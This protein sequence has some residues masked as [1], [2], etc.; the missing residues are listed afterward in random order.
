MRT[1]CPLRGSRH[2][3]VQLKC[4]GFS[5]SWTPLMRAQHAPC[6]D[7]RMGPCAWNAL[8]LQLLEPVAVRTACPLRRSRHR[9]LQLKC[10]CF[11]SSWNLLMRAQHVP[12]ADHRM[13]PC[14]WNALVLQLLEPVAVR[15][16][17]PLL[18]S[19]HGFVQL[20]CLGF[21]SSWGPLMPAQHVPCA[22]HCMG[23]CTWNA[24][25][26]Q[27]LEPAAV[28]RAYPLCGS[29]PRSVQLKCIGFSSSWSPSM[30]AQHVPGAD[31]RMGPC[32]WDA[33]V[34]QLLEPAA[35]RRA[36]PLRGSRH[37]SVQPKCMVLPAPGAR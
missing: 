10:L 4:L 11:S 18:G 16:A 24:L 8:V 28:R 17:C 7:H 15:T 14:T 29:R 2:R 37:R 34:L 22:D 13:G 33:L 36:Y 27:L 31:H 25:V 1:A 12:C 23:P 19:R 30:R 6:A 20:R 3:S 35:A 26:L 9:S 5:S 21:S 32:T